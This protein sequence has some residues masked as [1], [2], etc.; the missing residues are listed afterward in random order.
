MGKLDKKN[1][2][3]GD[4]F[5]ARSNITVMLVNTVANRIAGQG[6]TAA[7]FSTKTDETTA[8][9][10]FDIMTRRTVLIDWCPIWVCIENENENGNEI[11]N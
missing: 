4:R 1:D 8:N 5:A 11:T 9:Q 3:S 7:Y 2:L 10:T 6:C